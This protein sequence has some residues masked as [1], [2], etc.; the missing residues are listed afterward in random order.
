LT[1]ILNPNWQIYAVAILAGLAMVAFALRKRRRVAEVRSGDGDLLSMVLNNMTQGVVLFDAHEKVL[2][3]NDRYVEM[4]G[5]S[6]KVVKAGCT[7]MDL[8]QNRITTGSLN[9]D[10]QKY[11]AEILTAVRRGESMNRI[12]ETPDGRSVLV[13]NRPVKGGQ[14]WIGTHD[15]ITERIH[16]ERKSA[17]LTEQERRRV[18]IE[19]EIRAFRESVAA[20][21]RTV[22]ESTAALKSI[23]VTLSDSSGHTSERAAGA[24]Q[25]S[26][27][28]ASNMT[29]TASAAEELIASIGEIGRQISQAAEVA[30]HSV[31]EAN[32]TNEQMT[33]LTD[34]VQE[35]GDVVNLIRNIAGQT[36]LLALNATIEAARAGEA[37]RGFAV[38]ASEVKSLAVQ[39]AKATEQ[40]AGQIDAVQSSTRVAVDAIR[41]NTGRMREIDGYTSAVALSLQQQD[42]ATD[43]ISHN[44]A[45]AAQGAKGMVGVLDEVTRAVSDT[46]SAAS[47]VLEASDT[48]EAAATSLQRG[49]EGF[50]GRVAV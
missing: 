36:N 9:I 30:S 16:A 46:R 6:S 40:I 38:V 48:V 37:G 17:A 10:P 32:T 19:T 4:Y 31:V 35:I 3:C 28:A 43:E 27:E 33:R 25:T 2:V 41:R 15:D 49:I 22:T 47:K 23:A 14:Y 7:L 13:V 39:T 44:V 34:T 50:L 29:A 1:N 26:N 42:S 12:V 8:I 24:A 45:S 18:E 21:L 11:R 5:L 20:V